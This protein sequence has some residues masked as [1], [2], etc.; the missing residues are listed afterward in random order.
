MLITVLLKLLASEFLVIG[1]RTRINQQRVQVLGAD[2]ESEEAQDAKSEVLVD[3]STDGQAQQLIEK[4][5]ND[6]LKDPLQGR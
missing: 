1:N 5:G 2:S 4:V 6:Y 3:H